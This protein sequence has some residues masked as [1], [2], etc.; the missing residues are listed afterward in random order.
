MSRFVVGFSALYLA[1]ASLLDREMRESI[2]MRAQDHH[3][4]LWPDRQAGNSRV[5]R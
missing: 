5:A 2:L 4:P 3:F 1:H